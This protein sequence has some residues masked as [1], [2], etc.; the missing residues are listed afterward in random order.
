MKYELEI[1]QCINT[2]TPQ[3][4]LELLNQLLKE[5]PVFLSLFLVE[6]MVANDKKEILKEILEQQ[7]TS[8]L[9][10]VLRGDGWTGY[11]QLSS[12]EN[13]YEFANREY[14]HELIFEV[15]DDSISNLLE[16]YLDAHNFY[17]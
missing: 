15:E 14:L 8:F 7:P 17:S 5:T 6:I 2:G 13:I 4:H 16:E 11:N 9:D 1:N 3:E 12:L 10:S